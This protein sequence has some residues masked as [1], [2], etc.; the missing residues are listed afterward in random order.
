MEGVVVCVGGFVVWVGVLVCVSGL[1]CGG[2]FFF[3][4]FLVFWCVGEHWQSQLDI[5]TL[6]QNPI[7]E[8]NAF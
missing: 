6:F 4:F 2:L 1:C 5:K 3:V 8:M 7:T